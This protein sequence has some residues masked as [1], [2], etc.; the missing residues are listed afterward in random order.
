MRKTIVFVTHD[1][2]E[3]VKLGD[4]IAIFGQAAAGPVRPP[5]ELLANPA[6]SSCAASSAPTP[7]RSAG[8]ASS[9]SPISRS[10]GPVPGQAVRVTADATVAAVLERML[11]NG[12][13]RA[14]IEVDGPGRERSL[15][16]RDLL[17]AA[18]QSD[19]GR[20]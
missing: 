7:R 8:S 5:A 3:A 13:D 11:R 9:G 4:R 17:V 15:A 2:D 1:I 20:R 16:L 19:Q 18:A 14:V 6:E 10:P 12:A